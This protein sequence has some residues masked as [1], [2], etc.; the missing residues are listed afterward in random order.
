MMQFRYP[1]GYCGG[2][3]STSRLMLRISLFSRQIPD[4]SGHAP[5]IENLYPGRGVREKRPQA[6]EFFFSCRIMDCR[7]TR[8]MSDV[9]QIFS[10]FFFVAKFSGYPRRI[11]RT[12]KSLNF[13]LSGHMMW[14]CYV[15][16]IHLSPKRVFGRSA[17]LLRLKASRRGGQNQRRAYPQFVPFPTKRLGS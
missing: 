3:F 10:A 17:F 6:N 8:K 13:A 14:V 1:I 7:L 16:K 9:P 5:L 12:K 2:E 15:S 11:Q 4:S